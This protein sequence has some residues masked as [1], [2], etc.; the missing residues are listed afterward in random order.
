MNDSVNIDLKLIYKICREKAIS[1]ALILLSFLVFGLA[2]FFISEPEFKAT[3]LVQVSKRMDF[4]NSGVSQ[5]SI[6]NLLGNNNIDHRKYFIIEYINSRAF[7]FE[8][9]LN[10]DYR[11]HIKSA[12]L[13]EYLSFFEEGKDAKQHNNNYLLG[14]AKF[15][16]IIEEEH[17]N[18]LESFSVIIDPV[19]GFLQLS[20]LSHSPE[21]ARLIL[22]NIIDEANSKI[23]SYDLKIIDKSIEYLNTYASSDQRSE[24]ISSVNNLLENMLTKKMLAE[25]NSEYAINI[26]DYPFSSS[27]PINPNFLKY[28]LLSII[29]GFIFSMIYIMFFYVAKSIER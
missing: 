2:S 23:R 7:F 27:E 19:S 21:S 1:I 3:S 13:L 29:G 6:F 8:F 24:I 10:S 9:I 4:E 18:F 20:Y 25:V 5:N 26:I 11:L 15:Q 12:E 22:E 16:N 28:L 14:E 17:S